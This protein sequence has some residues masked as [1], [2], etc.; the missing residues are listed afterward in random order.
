MARKKKR[1][2]AIAG[3]TGDLIGFG[4]MGVVGGVTGATAGGIITAAGPAAAPALP[5]MGGFSTVASF[6]G[7]I[8]LATGGGRALQAVKNLNL[9]PKKKKRR[10]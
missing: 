8:A 2:S 10:K 9:K 5:I 3:L 4:K 1:K 6:A 7:P